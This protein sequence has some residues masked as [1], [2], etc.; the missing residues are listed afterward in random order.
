[1]I[2]KIN[3][4]HNKNISNP[5]SATWTIPHHPG[6]VIEMDWT[7]F[8]FFLAVG[9]HVS[10]TTT[11]WIGKFRVHSAIH[12]DPNHIWIGANLSLSVVSILSRY[13]HNLQES[14]GSIQHHLNPFWPPQYF[15]ST[16]INHGNSLLCIPEES[17]SQQVQSPHTQIFRALSPWHF[18][19]CSVIINPLLIIL[20][21]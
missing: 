14:P 15:Y 9:I 13:V 6:S 18:D 21:D 12:S 7:F 19:T 8:F 16:I 5:L 20:A 17:K 4:W 3:D 11:Y 10:W 1:M 2:K